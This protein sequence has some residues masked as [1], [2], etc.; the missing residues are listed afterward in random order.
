MNLLAYA[1]LFG[2]TALAADGPVPDLTEVPARKERSKCVCPAATDKG[3]VSLSGY[4]VDAKIIPGSDLRSYEDRM[5]TIFDVDSS[6]DSSITG[7]TAVW[8]NIS[9]NACGVSFDYGKK[10]RV[11]A[12]WNGDGELETDQCLMGH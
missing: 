7:R 3:V 5:A 10:Y 12:R 6:S 9:E 1:F 8:H 11:A 2:M 4:V